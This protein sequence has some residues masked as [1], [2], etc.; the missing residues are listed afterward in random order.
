MPRILRPSV[1]KAVAAMAK[2]AVFMAEALMLRIR[3]A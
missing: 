2:A 3:I 1:V